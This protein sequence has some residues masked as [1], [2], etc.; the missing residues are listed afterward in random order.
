ML[1]VMENNMFNKDYMYGITAVIL[2]LITIAFGIGIHRG[3][4][5]EQRNAVRAGVAHYVA[6]EQGN[7]KFEY[8]KK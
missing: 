6:D 5:F 1:C 3:V 4:K 2:V 8:I 7:P